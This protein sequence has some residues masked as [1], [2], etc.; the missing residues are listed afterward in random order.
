MQIKNEIYGDFD[1]SEEVLIELM[2][3]KAI[4]RLKGIDQAGYSKVFYVDGRNRFDHSIGV[5]L[6]LR[7][8]GASLD[9]QIAGLLHDV[10]HY[11]FSHAI[12]YILQEG[13]IDKQDLQD[14]S[15][16]KFLLNSDIPQI[17]EKHGYDVDRVADEENFSM[18]ETSLP[19][20]CADRLDYSLKDMIILLKKDVEEIRDI[21]SHLKVDDAKKWYFDDVEVGYVFAKYFKE[22]NDDHYSGLVSASMFKSIKDFIKCA[23]DKGYIEENDLEKEDQYVIDKCLKYIEK[24]KEL[25]RFWERMNNKDC[26]YP[27][28]NNYEEIIYCKSRVVDPLCLVNNG[29]KRVS[30]VYKEWGRVIEK[31]TIVK[32]HYLAAS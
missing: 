15:K 8:Y 21:I 4:Q 14:R 20:I 27:D 23:L 17:L 16:N 9:E 22:L 12:D 25:K 32:K 6:L 24:D 5:F 19:D 30:E 2:D 11:A 29:L 3:S 28:E 10:S 1:I 13:N 7:K 31:E 26:F 18:L